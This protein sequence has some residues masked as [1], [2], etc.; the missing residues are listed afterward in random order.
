[1]PKQT[2]PRERQRRTVTT[3]SKKTYDLSNERQKR[4]E[5]VNHAIVER[6]ERAKALMTWFK[7]VPRG[8][9]SEITS[10]GE[11]VRPLA[12]D[13]YKKLL[14]SWRK[15]MKWRQEMDDV[16]SVMIAVAAS[17]VQ[18][19]DQLFLMVIGNP[20]GSKSQFCD[21]LI[22]SNHCS[23]VEHINGMISGFVDEQGNDYSQINRVNRKCMISS[24]GDVMINSPNFEQ[25]MSQ[26]RRIFDGTISASYKNM[27]EDRVYSGLRLTW[28]IAGTPAML[29]RD[30]ASLGD[31][32][33]KIYLDPPTSDERREILK[34]TSRAAWSAKDVVAT[35]EATISNPNMIIARQ[36]LAGYVDHLRK[37]SD[38]IR[39]ID[40]K[41]EYFD[42]CEELSM[43][44]SIARARPPKSEETAPTIEEPYRINSQL[45]RLMSFIALTLNKKKVDDEVMMRLIKVG[46]DTSRGI[47]LDLLKAMYREGGYMNL[48]TIELMSGKDSATVTK[49]ISF[50][51]KVGVV[52]VQRKSQGPNKRKVLLFGLSDEM[53]KLGDLFF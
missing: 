16:L 1:M 49:Y 22:L 51:R 46:L 24:E 5:G 45:V 25:S 40:C 4:L 17:T 7:P 10:T 27:K 35:S 19:G 34:R 12:C 30:Q 33:L 42:V 20:S 15:A 41:Q 8:W 13:S 11:K 2:L 52:D 53:K 39:N 26:L 32:F 28:I 14:M 44:A 48:K 21:G 37:S 18:Q 50:Y 38:H 29:E 3:K 23:Q 6:I 47:S 31:R 36:M 43:L 9:I